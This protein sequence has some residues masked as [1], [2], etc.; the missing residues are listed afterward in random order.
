MQ[1]YLFVIHDERSSIHLLF[2]RC[3]DG[4]CD[5]TIGGPHKSCMKMTK[6][7][8]GEKSFTPRG[9]TSP[10]VT[11]EGETKIEGGMELGKRILHFLLLMIVIHH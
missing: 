5:V 1:K 3:V 11:F 6:E 10:K 4:S 7:I 2:C 8:G 9:K